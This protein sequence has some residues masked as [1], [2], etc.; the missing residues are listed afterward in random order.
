MT[1]ISLAP[2]VSSGS[3]VNLSRT[4]PVVMSTVP[5]ITGPLKTPL[6]SAVATTAWAVSAR[7]TVSCRLAARSGA[8]GVRKVT[9]V[10]AKP[11]LAVRQPCT[12][13]LDVC[14]PG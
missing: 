11:A 10:T 9:A 1:G 14:P 7:T 4:I 6:L 12:P 5:Q 3:L 13:M 8:P 2:L